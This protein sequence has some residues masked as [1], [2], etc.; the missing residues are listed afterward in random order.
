[1]QKV[2]LGADVLMLREREN[3]GEVRP[4]IPCRR[5]E[6]GKGTL[7][8]MRMGWGSVCRRDRELRGSCG[9]R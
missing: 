2:A 1:M 4:G 3:G 5:L 8:E 6:S 9:V 7:G